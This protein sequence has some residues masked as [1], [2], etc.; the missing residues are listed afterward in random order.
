MCIRDRIKELVAGNNVTLNETTV[1]T[2]ESMFNPPIKP[3]GALILF[4]PSTDY[5][6]SL[7]SNKQL[8]YKYSNTALVY[9]IAAYEVLAS[10][11]YI[12]FV[13][14]VAPKAVHVVDCKELTDDTAPRYYSQIELKLLHQCN[15]KIFPDFPL[16]PLHVK[17]ESKRAILI[18]EYKKRG[19]G[20]TFSLLG[21]D[22]EFWPKFAVSQNSC[23]PGLHR[24]L[25]EEEKE[26]KSAIEAIGTDER[27]RSIRDLCASAASTRKFRNEP[28]VAVLGTASQNPLKH[29]CVSSI[30][31]N[32]P[33]NMEGKVVRGTSKEY[34][35]NSYGFMLD[36]GEGCYGQLVDH[37]SD[38]G[39]V[40][41]VMENLKCIFISHHHSDHMLGLIKLIREADLVLLRRYGAAAAKEKLLYV[42]LPDNM[43]RMMVDL[44]VM[45]TVV[46]P[47]RVRIVL[48]ES[49]SPDTSPYYVKPYKNPVPQKEFTKE[50]ADKMVEDLYKKAEAK[51]KEMWEHLAKFLCIKKLHTYQTDHCT[52]S[53]GILI[54]GQDW[55]LA[56]TGDTFRCKTVENFT[57]DMDLL[58]HECTFSDD[59]K[60]LEEDIKHTTLAQCVEIFDKTTPWRMLLT[61]FSNKTKKIVNV[62]SEHLERKIFIGF[63][64]LQFYLSDAEWIYQLQPLLEA[65]I[66]ND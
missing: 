7:L 55:K 4:L 3:T 35:G 59:V 53:H 51:V 49:L 12:D 37:F 32:V 2:S 65:L 41:S 21:H 1:I 16:F 54:E 63:D 66:T 62:R 57:R 46:F 50:Q 23:L 52:G 29:R 19:L 56:Y 44:L 48:S 17:D 6:P 38:M 25:L 43:N 39:I 47:E 14:K 40:D 60:R 42:I 10:A 13:A 11:E 5:I 18:D 36:T 22:Y 61:H 20:L 45:P 31:V 30:Y 24:P 27:L 15:S 33:G 34:Y 64:H 58:I 26:I 8:L 9:H 28:F